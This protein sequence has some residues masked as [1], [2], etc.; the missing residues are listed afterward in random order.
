MKNKLCYIV[1]SIF[2]VFAFMNSVFAEGDLSFSIDATVVGGETT[3]VKGNEATIYVSLISQTA[4]SSCTFNVTS[5][6]GIEF[7]SKTAMNKY[8]VKDEGENIVVERVNTDVAFASG[9]NALELKYKINN[10]GKV[11]I[12]AV[13]CKSVDEKTGTTS[14]KVINFKTKEVTDDTSLSNLTVTGGTLSPKFASTL[15]NYTVQL[16]DTKFSLNMT[17]SNSNYQDK[18]VVTDSEGNTLDANNITFKNDGGQGIMAITITVNNKTKY[19]LGVTYVQEELDNS[20]SSLKIGDEMINLESGKYDYSVK[21]GKDISSVKIEAVLKDSNNFRFVEG[22]G[23]TV[24]QIPSSST[25]YALMIEPIDSTSG[26]KGV[27]YMI[28]VT[29]EGV[30][31]TENPSSTPNKP[32]SS[33]YNGNATTNPTTGGISMFLMAFILIASLIGSMYLYQKNLEGYN[34]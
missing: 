22:N 24:L 14:D 2:S 21:V 28:S 11:T 32:A 13:N 29:R 7:V 4:L 3:I 23:P 8:T 6:A 12:K 25:A 1:L 16:H 26:G 33:N 5:D 10:D 18:I 20:L 17:A 31:S 19:E 30:S 9:E 27:T 15:T 34:K